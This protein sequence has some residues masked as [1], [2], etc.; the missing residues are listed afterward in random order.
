MPKPVQVGRKQR[1]TYA[2]I[3][4]VGEMPNLIEIL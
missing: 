1:M 2:K 4:E 3:N